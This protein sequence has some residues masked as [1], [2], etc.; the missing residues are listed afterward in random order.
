MNIKFNKKMIAMLLSG[1]LSISSSLK[2]DN[3]A[4]DVNYIVASCNVRIRREATVD[5]DKLGL[6]RTG[7]ELECT[8]I[9][10][11]GWYEVIYNG[12]KAYVCGDYAYP[13][14]EEFN[15][16]NMRLIEALTNVR[17]RDDASL[18]GTQIGLLKKGKLL[19]VL[20]KL[21]N[22]WYEVLYNGNKAY[23]C[24]DYVFEY[25]KNFFSFINSPS[26]LVSAT[27]DTYIYDF[28]NDV[29]DYDSKNI[30]HILPK[31]ELAKVLGI[32][33]D[34]FLISSQYGDGYIKRKDVKNLGDFFVVI[35][36]S[37]QRLEL[38]KNGSVVLSS[39]VVTGKDKTPTSYGVYSILSKEKDRY[40]RG[41]GYSSHVD[42]WMPF[43]GGQGLH[44]ASWRSKFGGKIYR[45]GGSHG[46]VNL[47][48]DVAK[49]LYNEV[50]VGTKVLVKK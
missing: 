38:Y 36:V 35:D 31:Y 12:E 3:L 6:L 17:I 28:G 33:G 39:S 11:N 22:G 5:S 8:G 19:Q 21:D 46:C 23:V 27:K 15:F 4:E 49:E 14:R 34:Y 48:V 9:T 42:Y 30:K 13:N 40:L 45:N 24:G 37:D 50:E 43:N 47:P 10:D 29:F 20:D 41:R 1:A 26:I 16:D 18:E 7:E 25:N 2:K 32:N 44:D